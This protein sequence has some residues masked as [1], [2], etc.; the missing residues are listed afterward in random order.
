MPT[1]SGDLEQVRSNALQTVADYRHIVISLEVKRITGSRVGSMIWERR[2]WIFYR[3]FCYYMHVGYL[4]VRVCRL[5]EDARFRVNFVFTRAASTN[6]VLF[7]RMVIHINRARSMARISA[8]LELME[9]NLILNSEIR[10][11]Y[12]VTIIRQLRRDVQP[13][14]RIFDPAGLD[15][16]MWYR[17]V[18]RL[19]LG[20]TPDGLYHPDPIPPPINPAETPEQD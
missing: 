2:C 20:L 11:R 6:R 7:D 4:V 14:Y 18:C 5:I 8:L 10:T 17:T 1:N 9:R 15:Q 16:E 3:R 13:P 12:A 19:T